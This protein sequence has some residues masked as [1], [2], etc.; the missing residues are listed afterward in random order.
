MRSLGK[1]SDDAVG[2]V[3]TL[4]SWLVMADTMR[5][6]VLADAEKMT[7]EKDADISQA[8]MKPIVFVAAPDLE[9]TLS[10]STEATFLQALKQSNT[11][12]YWEWRLD[13]VHNDLIAGTSHPKRKYPFSDELGQLLPW[14][15]EFGEDR[16]DVA[17]AGLE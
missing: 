2:V 6:Q 9:P 10:V 14:L 15:D 13:S 1:A 17:V 16:A 7:H 4:D 3:L 12:K 5:K 8:D 11:E